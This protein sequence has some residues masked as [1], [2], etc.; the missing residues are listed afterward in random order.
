V[1]STRG[2]DDPKQVVDEE[3]DG[4]AAICPVCKRKCLAPLFDRSLEE[5]DCD[6]PP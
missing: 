4:E 5:G 1:K 3:H 2:N 6:E